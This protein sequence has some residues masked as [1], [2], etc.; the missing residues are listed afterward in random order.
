VD[1]RGDG[2]RAVLQAYVLENVPVVCVGDD[3]CRACEAYDGCGCW[4]CVEAVEAED[5]ATDNGGG[6]RSI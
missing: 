3:P 4:C 1:P 5:E 6:G 2:A